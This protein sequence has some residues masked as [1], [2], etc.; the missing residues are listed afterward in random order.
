MRSKRR[1]NNPFDYELALV[2]LIMA[3]VVWGNIAIIE[4]VNEKSFNI[5]LSISDSTAAWTVGDDVYLTVLPGSSLIG[6]VP[7]VN[8]DTAENMMSLTLSGPLAETGWVTLTPASGFTVGSG[9]KRTV[10]L[11]VDVPKG[12][13]GEYS[14]TLTV[15]GKRT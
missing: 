9:Q 3:L 10:G 6:S 12:M 1:K 4:V 5:F 7:V 15:V 8:N 14:G 11:A 13:T 2:V